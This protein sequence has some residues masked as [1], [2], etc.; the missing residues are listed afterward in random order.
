MKNITVSVTDKTYAIGRKWA[1]EHG[2]SIS[3]AVEI[4]MLK[5]PSTTSNGETGLM[6]NRVRHLARVEDQAARIH[7]ALEIS[8]KAAGRKASQSAPQARTIYRTLSDL[9]NKL[10]KTVQP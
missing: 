6:I 2:T 7:A 8:G 3:A 5:L 4:L 10:S 1:A 9:L